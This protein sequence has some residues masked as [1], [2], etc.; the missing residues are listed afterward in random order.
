M[1]DTIGNPL[2]YVASVFRRGSHFVGDGV[3]GLARKDKAE[4]KINDLTLG[5]LRVVLRKGAEDFAA[6]RTDVIFIVLI[7]PIIGFLL[8]WAAIDRALI[9]LVFPMISGFALLGPVFAVGLYEMSR[10]REAG[11][12]VSWVDGFG[13]FAS[14]S[15]IPILVLGGYLAAIFVLWMGVAIGL[16]AVT[17]GPDAPTSITGFLS[18]IFQTSAGWIMLIAGVGIGFIFAALVL[19]T[20]VV[21]FPLLLDRAVGLPQAVVTSVKVTRRNPVVIATWGLIVAGML[22]FGVVTLFVGLIF[23]LPILGHG[24]WHLYR[25]AIA[26]EIDQP[27]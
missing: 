5:D 24:T 10:R 15:F 4:I 9:P 8:T 1:V 6:M 27:K 18:D 17:L 12:D 19:A 25:Q 2:T 23:V 13:V 22:A 3:A 20:S 7:Y 11:K 21:S 14:P 16:Y 26:H